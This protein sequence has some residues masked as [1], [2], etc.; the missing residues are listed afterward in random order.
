MDRWLVSF[1]E[2]QLRLSLT[3]FAISTRFPYP[4]EIRRRVFATAVVVVVVVVH[5]DQ[6][7]FMYFSLISPAF[8]VIHNHFHLSHNLYSYA[9]RSFAHQFMRFSMD[10]YICP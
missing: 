6:C 5:Y 9:I 8:D 3:H 2:K 1:R 7:V 10:F 4:K